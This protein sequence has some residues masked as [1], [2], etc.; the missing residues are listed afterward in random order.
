[1]TA[2]CV[3]CARPLADSA[4]ACTGCTNRA[5]ADLIGDDHRDDRPGIIH[6]APAARD[7]A[8]GLSANLS[9]S[10]GAGKPG[11]RIPLN[12]AAAAKLDGIANALGGWVRIVAEERG[13][14]PERIPAGADTIAPAARFLAEHLE[15]LRHREFADEC[16]TDIEVAAR[17][18]RGIVRGPAEQ[19]Y[20]GPCGAPVLAEAEPEDPELGIAAEYETRICDGDVYGYRGADTGTCRTCG[21]RVDQA[22]RAAWLDELRRDW[23]F[24][25][26]EISD[27]Y[28][29]NVKTVRSWHNRGH[30]AAHGHDADGT[31]LHN[32]GDVLDLAAA[33]AAR[34]EESRAK[35]ARRNR[36]GAPA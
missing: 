28:G 30:L 19:K 35:R 27:A 20:L 17:V 3:R 29:I 31:P 2:Q 11:S 14:Y 6:T 21:A 26:K 13:V 10:G 22:E 9:G 18:L 7:I 1:V 8:Y 25:A 24:T 5:R 4:Y 36:E 16:F 12:L 33:D 15:W 34:R 23:L 32:V